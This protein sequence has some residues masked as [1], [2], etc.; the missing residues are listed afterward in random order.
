MSTLPIGNFIPEKRERSRKKNDIE[1]HTDHNTTHG[2]R[3]E[4]NIVN[5]VSHSFKQEGWFGFQ[6]KI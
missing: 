2:M 4:Q 1:C 6:N 5:A 3:M